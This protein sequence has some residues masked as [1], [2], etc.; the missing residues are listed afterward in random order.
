[1]A[2]AISRNGT[3]SSETPCSRE[4]AGA[5]LQRQSVQACR[6]ERVHRG[7]AV[8]ALAD[9]RGDTVLPRHRD[10]GRHETV[11][12]ERTVHRRCEADHRG[13]HAATGHRDHGVLR[14]DPRATIEAVL[15]GADAT[16]RRPGEEQRSRR[17][18]ERLLRAH[19][20]RA[21]R[22]D[23]AQI[24]RGSAGEV[25]GERQV[26]LERQVDDAIRS[27]R[28]LWRAHGGHRGRRAERRPRRPSARRLTRRSGR[29]RRPVPSREELGNNCGTDVAGGAGDE[30]AHGQSPDVRY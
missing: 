21:D 14:I 8:G 19:R 25:A 3:P 2:S 26:V 28:S 6:V 5:R 1:M 13:A 17:D 7:P 27:R 16:R 23:G 4:P 11:M 18:H 30:Y 9:V 10:Q 29:D 22:L 15:F 24:G 12:V 20:A